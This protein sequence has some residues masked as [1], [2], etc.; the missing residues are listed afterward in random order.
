MWPI[1]E[2]RIKNE[3]REDRSEDKGRSETQKDESNEDFTRRTVYRVF[4]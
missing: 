1:S 4:C 2:G 3:G